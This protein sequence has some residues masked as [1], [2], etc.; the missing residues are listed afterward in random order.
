M[1]TTFGI[2]NIKSLAPK[3]FRRLK[4]AITLLADTISIILLARG[5]TGDSFVMLIVRVGISGL[6]ESMEALLSDKEDEYNETEKS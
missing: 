1:T 5:Y 3:W 6:L 4:R 2:K